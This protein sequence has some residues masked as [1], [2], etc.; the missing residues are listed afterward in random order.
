MIKLDRL[1]LRAIEDVDSEKYH[2][3]INDPDTNYWRGLYHPYSRTKA[4]NELKKLMQDDPSQLSLAITDHVNEFIGLIGLRSICHR[5]RRAEIWIYIGNKKFWNKKIGQEALTGLVEYA[6]F[7]MNLHRVWL[8]CDPSHVS[9]VKCYL[10]CGFLKEGILI[11]GYYRH[12]K[13]HNTML[14]G[15]TR[16]VKNEL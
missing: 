16:K 3:W 7:S 1:N 9:A 6:F 8:E 14:M 5:S 12:G 11:D 13:F 4:E 2:T 10:N 15:Q